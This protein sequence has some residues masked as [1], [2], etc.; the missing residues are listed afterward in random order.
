MGEGIDQ[1]DDDEELY[2]RILDVYYDPPEGTEVSPEA[3]APREHDKTGISLF[4]AKYVSPQEVIGKKPGKRYW[5]PVLRAGDLKEG[6]LRI[7]PSPEGQP[8][9]HAEIPDM[10]HENR[11]T[12]QV[13]EAKQ[14]LARKLCRRILGPYPQI[15]LRQFGEDP[16]SPGGSRPGDLVGPLL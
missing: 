13:E 14:L 7:L 9:G 3:F 4:R 15:M 10:T 6:G 16:G 11:H 5:V 2:R 12:D 8:P 1:I